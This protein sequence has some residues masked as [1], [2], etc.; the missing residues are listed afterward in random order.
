MRRSIGKTRWAIAGCYLETDSTGDEPEFTSR[1]QISILNT[2]TAE[3][4]ITLQIFYED[5]EPVGPYEI[6]VRALRLRKVRLNDLI[7][8]EAP[9]LGLLCACVIQADHP[10]VIQ[11]TR[12][13]T[14]HRDRACMGSVAYCPAALP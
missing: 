6:H 7:F 1:E 11:I 14:S 8:P 2:G 5:R 3:A 12:V 10:V 4:V 9:P 13:D